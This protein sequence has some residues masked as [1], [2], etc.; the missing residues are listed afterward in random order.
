MRRLSESTPAALVISTDHG[1]TYL[2]PQGQQ[3]IIPPSARK[4][5]NYKNHRRFIRTDRKEVLN[6]DEWFFLDKNLFALHDN[7]AVARGWRYIERQPQGYTHGGLSPEET[8]LPFLICELGENEFERLQPIYEQATKPLRL[9]VVGSLAVRVRNPY[10][11]II[12]DLEIKLTDFGITFTPIDIEPQMEAQTERVDIMIPAKTSV[13]HDS[14]WVNIFVRFSVGGQERTDISKLRVKI[15][16]LF[17]TE[18]DD[19]FGAM[20]S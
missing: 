4:D 5:N 7:Y 11:D 15:R 1:A 8:I 3:L 16:Q 6:N 19:E 17:K 14:I 12:E 18:L 20:F 13:E 10:R 9:G 2:R